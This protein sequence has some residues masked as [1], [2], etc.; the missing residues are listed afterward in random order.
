MHETYIIIISLPTRQFGKWPHASD[1]DAIRTSLASVRHVQGSV[2]NHT[3]VRLWHQ[4]YS[5]RFRKV[6]GLGYNKIVSYVCVT[7]KLKRSKSC[8]LVSHV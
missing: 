5:L 1:H 4:N 7:V 3:L 6:H 2:L 8:L